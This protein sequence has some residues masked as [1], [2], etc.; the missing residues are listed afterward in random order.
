M[1]DLP[2]RIEP[3]GGGEA[4]LEPETV[5]NGR[6]A[7][8]GE[9]DRYRLAVNP[10]EEWMIQLEAG[11]LGTSRLYG[12]LTAYDSQ[13]NRLASAGDDIPEVAVF[14]AVLRGLRT[15]SDPFLR[16][17]VPEGVQELL[18]CG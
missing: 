8:P 15:N 4:R 6:I 13:G 14:S 7:N 18:D 2:E 1:G 16:V 9:V 17:K 3:S 11:G 5:V 10:G 12:R